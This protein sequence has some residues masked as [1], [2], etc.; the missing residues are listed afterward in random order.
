MVALITI[1]LQ[2]GTIKWPKALWTNADHLRY[3]WLHDVNP[4]KTCWYRRVSDQ[5]PFAAKDMLWFWCRERQMSRHVKIISVYNWWVL[6]QYECPVISLH[7]TWK[8]AL[9]FM[10]SWHSFGWLLSG[11]ECTG[12]ILTENYLTYIYEVKSAENMVPDLH[13]WSQKCSA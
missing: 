4:H 3:F 11:Q 2:K 1:Q 9:F 10:A 7:D 8:P 6:S 13:L 12:I 5:K